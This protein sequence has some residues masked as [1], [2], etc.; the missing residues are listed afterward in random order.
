MRKTSTRSYWLIRKSILSHWCF[1]N[2]K[3]VIVD[4]IDRNQSIIINHIRTTFFTFPL[5]Q[6]LFHPLL[7]MLLNWYFFDSVFFLNIGN[8]NLNYWWILVLVVVQIPREYR[9]L[10]IPTWL[11]QKKTI[12]FKVY[13]TFI[14]N[15]I[16]GFKNAK[17]SR[18]FP[19]WDSRGSSHENSLR[20]ISTWSPHDSHMISA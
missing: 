2:F 20:L 16:K 8:G 6:W 5:A 12:R 7:Q 1:S 18:D 14:F 13:Q 4:H 17:F 11:P 19:H 10:M 9:V 15:E 3:Q